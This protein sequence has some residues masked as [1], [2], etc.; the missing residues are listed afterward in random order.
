MTDEQLNALV[1]GL[2]EVEPGQEGKALILCGFAASA[3]RQLMR[4]REEAAAELRSL[5]MDALAAQGQAMDNYDR[6]EA[7]EA[8]LREVV[9]AWDWWQVDTYDRCSSV[10][11]D[12]IREARDFLAK[13]PPA[14]S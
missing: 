9:E 1:E 12:A 11:G 3:I 2:D 5:A 4:E 13:H 8:K 6:A 7:A 10:P 14:P